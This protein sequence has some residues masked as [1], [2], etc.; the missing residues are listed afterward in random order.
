MDELKKRKKMYKR[1]YR[2]RKGA[3]ER[4]NRGTEDVQQRYMRRITEIQQ[5]PYT[6]LRIHNTECFVKIA[7]REKTIIILKKLML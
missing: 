1:Y 7:T 2:G 3:H 6:K 5:R 4:N